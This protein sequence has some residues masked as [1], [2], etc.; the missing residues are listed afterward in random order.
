[1]YLFAAGSGSALAQEPMFTLKRIV[2]TAVCFLLSIS[3]FSQTHFNSIVPGEKTVDPDGLVWYCS[4]DYYSP[5]FGRSW[6]LK[7]NLA[8]VTDGKDS[9]WILF[10]SFPA[11]NDNRIST[12]VTGKTIHISSVY[13]EIINN[14]RWVIDSNNHITLTVICKLNDEDVLRYSQANKSLWLDSHLFGIDDSGNTVGFSF[15]TKELPWDKAKSEVEALIKDHP[16]PTIDPITG[17]F[18]N[19]QKRIR[20]ENPLYSVHKTPA[21]KTVSVIDLSTLKLGDYQD[22]YM[23]VME[24]KTGLCHIYNRHGKETGSFRTDAS[25][26]KPTLIPVYSKGKA[27][28]KLEGNTFVII[29]T[30]GNTIKQLGVSEIPVFTNKVPAGIVDNLLV[31]PS[32]KKSQNPMSPYIFNGYYYYD[33]NKGSKVPGILAGESGLI[34]KELGFLPHKLHDNR[35]LFQDF[36]TG[37]FGYMNENNSVSI[38]PSFVYAHDFSDGLAAVAILDGE[39]LLW[40]YIDTKGKYVINP[41]FTQ[42]P[43]DFHNGFAVIKK[44]ADNY[45]YYD[46]FIDKN[47]TVKYEA[48]YLTDFWDGYAIAITNDLFAKLVDSE[49]NS[50]PFVMSGN[51][52]IGDNSI[53]N[54]TS[55]TLWADGFTYSHNNGWELKDSKP[56]SDEITQ[57]RASYGS[58][59]PT[60]YVNRLGELILVFTQ[61]EF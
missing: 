35:R 46:A 32:F 59:V 60:G 22:G 2:I 52:S 40:G 13:S 41:V 49:L 50:S 24:T 47:G 39:Q 8:I 6:L 7:H 10:L 56:F 34:G 12:I 42:E 26:W 1:M 20:K 45:S 19:P 9:Q 57:T 48:R 36:N 44:R 21:T 28:A 3:S 4:N 29:D 51:H 31:L 5:V 11:D 43:K 27:V 37:K 14:S 25:S 55:H 15:S 16:A 23:S 61:S 38:A 30:L 58:D 17:L 33:V 53:V 18:V 54:H